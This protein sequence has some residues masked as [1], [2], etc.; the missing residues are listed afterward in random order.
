M[1]VV[2]PQ[3][4]HHNSNHTLTSQDHRRPNTAHYRTALPPALP[5]TA[6]S[7][8]ELLC[9]LGAVLLAHHGLGRL[10]VFMAYSE[11]LTKL[12]TANVTI[13]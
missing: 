6:Y 10:R 3:T 8:H 2:S 9:L 11:K 7:L 13:L 1:H 12:T 5:P 4:L